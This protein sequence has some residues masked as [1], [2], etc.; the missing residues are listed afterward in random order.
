MQDLFEYHSL[1][2]RARSHAKNTCGDRDNAAMRESEKC[3]KSRNSTCSAAF[4]FLVAI[5]VLSS[6][7]GGVCLYAQEKIEYQEDFSK[8]TGL[9]YEETVP[10]RIMKWT[11]GEYTMEQTKGTGGNWS[12]RSFPFNDQL[13][14]SLDVDIRQISGAQDKGFG[15]IFRGLD[16]DSCY[17]FVIAPNGK[18]AVIAVTSPNYS[19]V[20]P[21]RDCA[22]RPR[23]EYNHLRVHHEFEV[24]AFYVNDECIGCFRTSEYQ[25][26][27][28]RYGFYLEDIMKIGVKSVTIRTQQVDRTVNAVSDGG[29]DL[30]HHNLGT[31]VNTASSEISALV[32]ADDKTLYMI[33]RD[34]DKNMGA[35]HRDDIW[36][37]R[38]DQNNMWLPA[39]NIGT[40]LNNEANNSVVTV[41]PDNNTMLLQGQYAHGSR[42]EV[43]LSI[44]HRTQNGWSDPRPIDIDSFYNLNPYMEFCL[45]PDERV[46]IAS[47]ERRN[48]KG[49]K[50]F[51]VCSRKSDTSFS[52]PVHI[53]ELSTVG[54]DM[55]PYI[56]TDG[57]TLYFSTDARAGYGNEDIFVTTRLDSTWQHWSTPRNLGPHINTPYFDAYF[58]PTTKG[59]SAYM[60][61]YA[62]SYG[63][64]DIVRVAVPPDARPKHV[65]LISGHVF[66]AKTKLPLGAGVRYENLNTNLLAGAA[67]SNPKDGA[68][69]IA[70]PAGNIYGFH[71][72]ADNYYPVSEKLDTRDLRAYQELNRDLYLVPIE[73]EATIR[74]N[75]LFFD[76]AKAELRDESAAELDRLIAF[77]KTHTTVS[78]IISGHTDNVGEDAANKALS[79]NRANAVM[80]YLVKKGVVRSRL[81]SAGYGSTKP[82]AANDSEE[83]RQKN[84]R[85][86]FVIDKN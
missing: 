39:E 62:N 66:D 48:G 57:A 51:Y 60:I 24:I 12:L 19:L 9:W 71:A 47:I 3:R 67:R 53:P 29:L 65:C 44:S 32:S 59:D 74:L 85:V 79:R 11:L 69:N 4:R 28:D 33:R 63:G 49:S 45:S 70:L 5:I 58:H 77:L 34:Y 78:I 7:R 15:L 40:P 83:G 36:F 14:W 42:D 2:V 76:F 23:G 56:A 6:G 31:N 75:N 80:T 73:R 84:R 64:A 82:I 55:A 27:G 22:V 13:D 10:G 16:A 38:R 72:E 18:A 17:L 54:C 41:S 25:S 46:L 50:D 26:F 52:K 1:K 8:N 37:S 30:H 68:Y 86:E 35:E 20:V 43:G 61:T 81:R 21:W